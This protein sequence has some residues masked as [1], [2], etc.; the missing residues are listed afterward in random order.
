MHITRIIDYTMWRSILHTTASHWSFLL[1]NPSVLKVKKH[2]LSMPQSKAAARDTALH[3]VARLHQYLIFKFC[4]LAYRHRISRHI[5]SPKTLLLLAFAGVFSA[6]THRH[7]DACSFHPAL[8]PI[9]QQV[10]FV[11]NH[12]YFS[13]INLS[14]YQFSLMT[15][16]ASDH[17]SSA[18]NK[19]CLTYGIVKSSQFSSPTPSRNTLSLS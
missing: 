12:E 11:S 19:I 17:V 1:R 13:Y 9:L 2:T 18:L 7:G 4:T 3:F 6:W 15:Y 8:Y 5:R 10:S 14:G 16:T